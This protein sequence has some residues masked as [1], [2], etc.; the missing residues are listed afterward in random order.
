[1]TSGKVTSK[2]KEKASAQTSNKKPKIQ[3]C[4]QTIINLTSQSSNCLPHHFVV[5]TIESS[6]T[7]IGVKSLRYPN[8]GRGLFSVFV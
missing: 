1:M 4:D 5:S 6:F 8:V 3:N 2:N 7:N